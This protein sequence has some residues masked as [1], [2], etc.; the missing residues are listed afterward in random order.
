MEFTVGTVVFLSSLLLL[1]ILTRV[2]ASNPESAV[3]RG[4]ILPGLMSVLITSGLTIGLLM[5]AFGGDGYFSSR[6]IEFAVI[7]AFALASVWGIGKLVSRV[8]SALPA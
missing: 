1:A 8:P 5:M 2:S 7:V 4:E 3:L 6:S